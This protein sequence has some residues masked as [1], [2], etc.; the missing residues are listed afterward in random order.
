LRQT[1]AARVRRREIAR[2]YI[3]DYL[4]AT[5][6][7][8]CG[9]GDVAVLEFDHTT[10]KRAAVANLVRHGYD[11]ARIAEE[12]ER[13][14]VVCVN[15]HRRRTASRGKSW[16]LDRCRRAAAEARPLRRRNV[17]FLLDVLD[18][19]SCVDC[20]EDDIVVLDFDHLGEKR[21]SVINLAWW[22]YSIETIEREIQKCEVRCA[23]CHRRRTIRV[24]RHFRHHWLSPRSS[25]G[26]AGAF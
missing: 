9:I 22:E 4:R 24:F 2:R 10:E 19:S 18:G 3:V 23:N 8:D 1:K 25:T 6:C 11:T 14:E 5:G 13:C 16:R 20:E 7:S 26:R 21:A 15:C 17:L 12:I